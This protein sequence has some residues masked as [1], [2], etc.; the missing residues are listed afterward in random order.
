MIAINIEMPKDCKD[1]IVDC[2]EFKGCPLIE[3]DQSEDCVSRE[4][5]IESLRADFECQVVSDID[6]S[7]YREE[8]QTLCNAIY[9]AQKKAIESLPPVQPTHGAYKK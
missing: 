5:A 6:F 9:E 7:K 8:I 2:A 3:I 4:Q 1:C